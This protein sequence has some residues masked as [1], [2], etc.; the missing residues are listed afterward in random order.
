MQFATLEDLKHQLNIETDTESGDIDELRDLNL[1]LYLEAAKE[2]IQ[3]QLNVKL[4]EELPQDIS[5]ED[6]KK[7]IVYCAQIKLAHLLIASDFFIH[8]EETVEKNLVEIPTGAKQ[9]LS[10]IR[11]WNA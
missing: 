4:V 1:K 10:S 11:R 7:Y 9:I 3:T 5:E 8:R 6:Q 2:R